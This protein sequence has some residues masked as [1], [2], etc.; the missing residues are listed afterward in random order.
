MFEGRRQPIVSREQKL[1]YAGIYVLKKMDLKP[2]DGGMEFPIVLPPELSPL[3]DVLQELVNA[4]LVEVNRRKARFEVTKKGLA[5]LGE[6]IDEAE[7]L[8]DEFDDESLEDAVAELRRR[9]V[10][11]LRARFLW[12][13]YDGELDDLVLFQQRRGATPVEPW[14]ADYLMSDAFYEA[15]KSDYE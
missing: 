11:V 12:G 3:E 10:D 5:Y 4:D 2:A 15:L 7:A 13:W 6:I 14:W 8:V 9:N 1:V